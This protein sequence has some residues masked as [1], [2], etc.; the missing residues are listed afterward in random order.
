[1]PSKISQGSKPQPNPRMATLKEKRRERE[2]KGGRRR[3]F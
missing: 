1:M 3:A 2:E